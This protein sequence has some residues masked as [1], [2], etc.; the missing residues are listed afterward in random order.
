MPERSV[1]S[2]RVS[3]GDHSTGRLCVPSLIH[4]GRGG[5]SPDSVPLSSAFQGS[6]Y[7]CQCDK[8][9]GEGGS[10]G[11]PRRLNCTASV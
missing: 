11:V 4:A 9:Q 2:P 8:E 1:L 6:D 5:W 10:K 7:V 3:G